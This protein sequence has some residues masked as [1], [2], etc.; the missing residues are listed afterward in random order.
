MREREEL[1]ENM[2]LLAQETSRQ[3]ERADRQIVERRREIDNQVR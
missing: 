1:I 3:T 2:E